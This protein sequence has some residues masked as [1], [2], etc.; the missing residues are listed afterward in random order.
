MGSLFFDA[1]PEEKAQ[2]YPSLHRGG[3]YI[4]RA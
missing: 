3:S 4:E 2:Q 1:K